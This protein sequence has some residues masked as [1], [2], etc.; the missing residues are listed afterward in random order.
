MRYYIL[1]KGD[2]KGPYTIDELKELNLKFNTKLCEEGSDKWKKIVEFEELLEVRKNI[3]PTPPLKDRI[4]KIYSKKIYKKNTLVISSFL[5]LLTFFAQLDFYKLD[6]YEKNIPYLIRNNLESFLFFNEYEEA[7]KEIESIKN[8]RITDIQKVTKLSQI[9]DYRLE[10]YIRLRNQGD[11]NFLKGPE[12]TK[13]IYEY[14]LFFKKISDKYSNEFLLKSKNIIIDHLIIFLSY[15]VLVFII[16]FL[17][18][19]ILNN[20]LNFKYRFFHKD[21]LILFSIILFPL[22]AYGLFTSFNITRISYRDFDYINEYNNLKRIDSYLRG[23]DPNSDNANSRI[24]DLEDDLF[25]IENRILPKIKENYSLYTD[26][27]GN[28]VNMEES[29]AITYL[30]LVNKYSILLS[31]NNKD[32]E[33]IAI[34]ERLISNLSELGYSYKIYN[35]FYRNLGIYYYHLGFKAVACENW[36]KGDGENS[37]GYWKDQ[38]KLLNCSSFEVFKVEEAQDGSTKT[39]YNNGH[40]VVKDKKGKPISESYG[41]MTYVL[42]ESF[43]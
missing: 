20:K 35:A 23:L 7:E 42:V 39:S 36:T 3:K 21:F 33:S 8:S 10:N 6:H 28:F 32:R 34:S 1:E 31:N 40:I 24:K 15:S 43:L 2:I 37:E 25:F 11:V 12:F 9:N 38:F 17:L 13:E 18:T 19:P 26:D 5:F 29:T 41:G 4:I 30:D 14:D 22:L 16:A 27:W